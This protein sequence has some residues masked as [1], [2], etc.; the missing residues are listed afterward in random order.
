MS[1]IFRKTRNSPS[2]Q[3]RRLGRMMRLVHSRLGDNNSENLNLRFS[4]DTMHSLPSY[5]FPGKNLF[6]F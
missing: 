5:C 3:R 1:L 4:A 2:T 6:L